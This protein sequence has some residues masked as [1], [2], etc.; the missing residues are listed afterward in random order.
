MPLS[1]KFFCLLKCCY[2]SLCNNNN[3][4]NNN[5]KIITLTFLII[6]IYP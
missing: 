4:D 3:N 2:E 5:I 6:S 1:E